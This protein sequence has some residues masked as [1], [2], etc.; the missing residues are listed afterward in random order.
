M[1]KALMNMSEAQRMS[2]ESLITRRTNG[3]CIVSMSPFVSGVK[4]RSTS[5]PVAGGGW[6]TTGAVI[7]VNK[8]TGT[9][10]RGTDLE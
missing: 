6:G 9:D 2:N 3:R 7:K 5:F 10:K 8:Y 1:G 4:T